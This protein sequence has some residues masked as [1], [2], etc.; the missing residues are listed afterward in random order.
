MDT[1]R[2]VFLTALTRRNAEK[3][4]EKTHRLEEAAKK[5]SICPDCNVEMQRGCNC[6]TCPKCSRLIH[7]FLEDSDAF[8]NKQGTHSRQ[9]G[10]RIFH[11]GH[12]RGHV[13]GAVSNGAGQ[14]KNAT[15]NIDSVLHELSKATPPIIVPQKIK[16]QII[17]SFD[18]IYSDKEKHILKE[19]KQKGLVIALLV[20]Y[21]LEANV[22]V[23]IKSFPPGLIKCLTIG[24]K[25]IRE[26]TASGIL[27]V[28]MNKVSIEAYGYPMLVKLNMD[29][30]YMDLIKIYIDAFYHN[31]IEVATNSSISTVIQ[32][33][34]YTISKKT[35]KP[36]KIEDV[37]G[38]HKITN[39]TFNTCLVTV[40]QYSFL[41]EIR[42]EF[43]KLGLLPP[44][45]SAYP[46]P[47]KAY[48][49]SESEA[50][51][52]PEV[53]VTATKTSFVEDVDGKNTIDLVLDCP[54]AGKQLE[55]G[56][57]ILVVRYKDERQKSITKVAKDYKTKSELKPFSQSS[58]MMNIR[59]VPNGN[60]MTVKIFSQN[61]VAISNGRSE[62]LSDSQKVAET[63]ATYLSNS[64]NRRFRL[65]EPVRAEM[66][67]YKCHY[68]NFRCKFNIRKV[69]EYLGTFRGQQ[70]AGG[71]EITR[72]C[73]KLDVYNDLST[74]I[75]TPEDNVITIKLFRT[76]KINYVALKKPGDLKPIHNWFIS[77]LEKAPKDAVYNADDNLQ[78]L[79]EIRQQVLDD[80][81]KK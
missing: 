38:T 23:D 66:I 5:E 7:V 32:C 44:D 67:N 27:N 70:I 54:Q 29:K 31:N 43:K 57:D 35:D 4:L 61:S 80:M 72:L 22:A 17:G 74:Y 42:A 34:I 2:T 3:R 14:L 28:D 59:Y 24:R 76:G 36:I 46:L 64:L 51:K 21:C 20:Y 56:G 9:Y 10:L 65:K 16:A 18:K 50:N 33:V 12:G 75:K 71:F 13:I 53:F 40:I 37:I 48:C 63:V 62:D 15:T 58:I 19:R 26:F 6:Y 60:E 77:T 78:R 79:N 8:E 69:Y 1:S 25:L 39:H 30:K 55:V 52:T 49:D 11:G 73:P 68:P 41:P 47:A 81:I 45:F